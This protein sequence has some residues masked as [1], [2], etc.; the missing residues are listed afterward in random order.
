MIR[1]NPSCAKR[2]RIVRFR[3][4]QSRGAWPGAAFADL[5]PIGPV[6]PENMVALAHAL[7]HDTGRERPQIR[8][9]A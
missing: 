4:R 1:R 8:T 6:R 5:P 2:H 3:L 7:R 9:P